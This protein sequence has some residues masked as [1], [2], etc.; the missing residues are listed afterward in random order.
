MHIKGTAA[1]AA[2]AS[3]TSTLGTSSVEGSSSTKEE[4]SS[5]P[6]LLVPGRSREGV[7]IKQSLR[8]SKE[9]FS[10][11]VVGVRGSW[12][13][14]TSFVPHHPGGDVIL[15]FAGMDATAQ[16]MAYHPP[17]V[18]KGRKPVGEYEFN[19]SAPGGEKMQSDWMALVDRYER[20]GK[21]KT[22]PAFVASRFA[23]LGAFLMGA[24]TCTWLYVKLFAGTRAFSG[25]WYSWLVLT[26]GAVCLAGFWQQSGELTVQYLTWE[27]VVL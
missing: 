19:P 7:P 13:N 15:E 6:P 14:V 3:A 10:K 4:Q 12:Y 24:L 8:S 25:P 9:S 22:P 16:F 20:E 2:A 26:L 17:S 27:E 1:V 18:L 5:P 23:I 11:V 21:F